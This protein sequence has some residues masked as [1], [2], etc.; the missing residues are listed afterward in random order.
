MSEHMDSC[1]VHVLV[2]D[3]G[4]VDAHAWREM[5]LN[6]YEGWAGRH[7]FGFKRGGAG[8]TLT[9]PNVQGLMAGECGLHR[10]VRISP[11]DEEH[12][13]Q[14][15]YAEV[16]LV[17]L[18]PALRSYVLDP[19]QSV[20]NHRTGE[21]TDDVTGVLTGDLDLL[22]ARPLDAQV[23]RLAQYILDNV[24]GEPSQ[25]QG[26]VDTAIRLLT[27]FYGARP[28]GVSLQEDTREPSCVENWPECYSGGYDPRCCRFPKSCSARSV[29][30]SEV[31]TSQ[32]GPE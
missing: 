29:A 5:L 16:R 10:L 12:R 22:T 14:S 6:M 17:G 3:M 4:D 1:I 23:G 18:S 32:G 26:A 21:Q 20:M 15:T 28:V 8:F 2:G 31:T 30:G 9:G 25:S 19:Y 13:R 27:N 7:G 24:P 11:F